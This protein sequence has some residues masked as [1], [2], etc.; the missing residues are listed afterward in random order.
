MLAADHFRL[1][2]DKR[3]GLLTNPSGV[4]RRR[5][6]TVDVLRRA[7]GVKLVALFAAEH[8]LGGDLPAG[9]EFPNSVDARTGLPVFSLYGPGPTRKPTS[10]MLRHVDVLVYDV[11]DTGCRSYTFISSMG[12]AMEAC[13]EAGKAFVVLDRPNPLGGRRVE[14]PLLDRRFRS[15]VGQ[16]EIP[17][18]YGLTCGELAYMINTE[19]WISKPCKL[20]I[21]RMSGWRRSMAWGDT[22]LPWIPTSPNIPRG[23]SPLY[24]VS[25][26]FLGALGGV[27]IG[28]GDGH[29]KPFESVTAPWLNGPALARDLN[30][31][32][33]LKGVEFQPCE[34]KHRDKVYRGVRIHFTDPAN[35]PLL[36]IS[37]HLLEAIRATAKRDLYAEARKAGKNFSLL[38]KVAGTD[39]VRAALEAAT[40]ARALT[41]SWR[42]GEEAFRQRR[43]RYLLYPD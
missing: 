30:R 36:A 13:A 20:T 28:I 12:L 29:H 37:F 10:G 26:G 39:A 42:A 22:G 5:E 34:L 32:S 1:L 14:G 6:S 8:G 41:Q 27:H 21:V 2:Q 23:N 33:P 35:A 31:R 3:V 16:W 17:Y 19:R 24:Y 18:V 25:T 9:Q 15:L 43:A 7:P 11:Q 40:P 38:D 4:N